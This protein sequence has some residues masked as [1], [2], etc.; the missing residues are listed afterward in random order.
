[1]RIGRHM[2]TGSQPVRALRTAR[3]I[4][5]EAVQVFVTNP[6]GWRT[7]GERPAE[8]DAFRAATAELGLAPVV[9][10]A[11]YLINLASPRDEFFE[12]SVVLLRATLDRAARYG[13][14]YVVL[15]IGSHMGAGE[16]AG[17]ARLAAGVRRVLGAGG[18]PGSA[19]L[20]EN[21][22][23]AGGELGYRFENL[24]AVLAAVPEHAARLGVCIDTAH[25]WGA[26]FDIGTA[27]GAERVL[28]EL[29]DTVGLG[30]VPVIHLNDTKKALGSHRDVHARVG[31]GIIGQEGLAALLRHPGLDHATALLE[32]PIQESEPGKPDWAHD[33]EHLR[34][35][36]ALAGREPVTPPMV[37][38][39]ADAP[40]PAAVPE[41]PGVP[42]AHRR[43]VKRRAHAAPTT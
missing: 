33:T 5:C 37:P 43:A 30:R 27:E 40:P 22:V 25:L 17:L 1:M 29:D 23:G 42:P 18:S 34:R 21:D 19:L 2:P 8:E 11:T 24:A 4:G 6:R 41:T 28:A 10:H 7:P 13:A 16:E 31:E 9:V 35:V 26:G 39:P 32:T 14:A 20:L 15:H 38:I 3:A 12:Q 36:L